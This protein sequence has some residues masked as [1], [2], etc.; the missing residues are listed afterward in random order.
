[1]QMTSPAA[2]DGK[3]GVDIDERHQGFFHL[4]AG[5]IT[6]KSSPS[7]HTIDFDTPAAAHNAPW[8][9]ASP[10][11]MPFLSVVKNPAK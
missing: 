7:L 8:L 1:M 4:T 6:T 3:I 2:D 11:P 9:I 10:G 5:K